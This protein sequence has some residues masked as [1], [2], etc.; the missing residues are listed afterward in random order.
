MIKLIKKKRYFIPS[1]IIIRPTSTLCIMRGVYFSDTVVIDDI[2]AIIGNFPQRW[3]E[4]LN[5]NN[6]LFYGFNIFQTQ[7]LKFMKIS[8][9]NNCSFI[10]ITNLENLYNDVTFNLNYLKISYFNYCYNNNNFSI[11]LPLTNCWK[12]PSEPIYNNLNGFY[13][14]LNI[15]LNNNYNFI[16]LS[17]ED[18]IQYIKIIYNITPSIVIADSESSIP[19]HIKIML[20]DI[21]FDEKDNMS[22]SAFKNILEKI[23]TL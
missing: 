18:Y 19:M 22:D 10:V 16:T 8:I 2:S 13:N 17:F 1:G 9:I 4:R 14:N 12:I 6:D 23:S 7:F 20:A 21:I 5:T 3:N 15:N 11:K